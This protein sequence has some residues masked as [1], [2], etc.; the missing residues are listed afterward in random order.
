MCGSKLWHNK[1]HMFVDNTILYFLVAD[2]NE[3]NSNLTWIACPGWVIS[4]N[5][6][7][8]AYQGVTSDECKL[9]CLSFPDEQCKGVDY[10]PS[11]GRCSFNAISR[12]EAGE[13]WLPEP[14]YVFYG[15]IRLAKTNICSSNAVVTDHTGPECVLECPGKFQID[16][17]V[18]VRKFY[19]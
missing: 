8:E 3:H 13:S 1:L 10:R 5:S 4:Y 15:Y 14:N 17:R 18:R 16:G 2:Q 19:L 7:G 6:V 11:D 9:N 12:L